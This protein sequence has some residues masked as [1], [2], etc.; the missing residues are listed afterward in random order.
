M[1]AALNAFGDAL[2]ALANYLRVRDAVLRQVYTKVPTAMWLQP[3][4]GDRNFRA[5]RVGARRWPT[6]DEVASLRGRVGA[7]EA[8]ESQRVHSD[9]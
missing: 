6:Q 7:L 5:Q 8:L 1:Q 2:T 9:P 4:T 3:R